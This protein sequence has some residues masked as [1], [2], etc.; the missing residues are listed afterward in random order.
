M[1]NLPKQTTS[2]YQAPYQATRLV[3]QFV[4]GLVA[5][6]AIGACNKQ[7]S[8]SASAPPAGGTT[9][10]SMRPPIID[11]A[12]LGMF[13]PL[14]TAVP[15]PPAAVALGKQ[16]FYETGLSLARD[17]SCNSCH[18]LNAY[19][20]DGKPVSTGHKGQVG[21]RNS[22]TVYNAYL[23]ATQFWDGREPTVEAQAKGPVMNP[24]EMAMPSV[25][26]IEKRL[27]ASAAY[28]GLF[29]AAFPDAKQPVTFDNMAIA[30]GAF[31]RTLVT[32]SRWDAFL[33]GDDAALTDDEKV[34]AREFIAA[35][36]VAC[37]SGA[38]LGGQMFQKLGSVRPWPA[39]KDR[40][41]ASVTNNPADEGMFK[42]PA[43]RN[44]AKTA[45]YLHDGSIS[46]LREAVRLMALH[47]LGKELDA[48]QLDA[49]VTFLGALTAELPAE[50]TT[51][52]APLL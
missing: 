14:P 13:A 27:R 43:L 31:E 51:P 25:A 24:V 9:P 19:G 23:H 46:S 28:K 33:A 17:V 8:D 10:V 3:T 4:A 52:V 2:P 38:T 6:T 30:I 12:S 21:T 36:C 45:P 39:I 35:G 7:P 50:M 49:I 48:T 20:V 29:A 44:V 32:P 5:V 40:G 16:L 22:P 42:V 11:R 47:Q 34:G 15:Q 26:V 1:N 37:H 41:R 18:M